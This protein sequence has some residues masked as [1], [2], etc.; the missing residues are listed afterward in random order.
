MSLYAGRE[1]SQVKHFI[2][3]KYLQRF[4]HII[5]TWK[6]AITYVDC[7]SGPWMVQA[8]DL[9]DSSFAIALR[10]L[11]AARE[12]LQER[13]TNRR[14]RA[15]F[16][17]K[18]KVS[19]AKLEAYARTQTDVQVRTRNASLDQSVSDILQFVD[20]GGP[21]SFPFF[22]IDPTGWTGFELDIISPLLKHDPGEVLI[23]LMIKF[24]RRFIKSPDPETQQSFD[25]TFGPYRPSIQELQGLS[26]E[27]LDDAIVAAY[28]DLVRTVGNYPY[29]CNAIVLQPDRDSTHFRLVYGTRHLKGVEVFKSAER[30]AMPVQEEN[31]ARV[32][33]R[34]MEKE[35]GLLFPPESM[36]RPQHYE[37]LRA[38]Y[39]NLSRNA[40]IH[41]IQGGEVLYDTLFATA[42]SFPI[43]CESDLKSWIKDWCKS[44]DI[45]LLGLRP[46]QRAPHHS[47]GI[48]IKRLRSTLR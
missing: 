35:G 32:R 17:E 26:D 42:L 10:E 25:R 45:E 22:L 34:R 12:T 46:G 41:R 39:F 47:E 43:V 16:L 44:G 33:G 27:D 38:R 7:F 11:R 19:Y 6:S 31:R 8:Q 3:G 2:I 28:V 9:A 37:H 14:I 36:G 40:V 23:N 15:Y 13:H 21:D 1:Q 18:D 5:F 30:Q 4:A 24:I 48:R 29:V 20:S